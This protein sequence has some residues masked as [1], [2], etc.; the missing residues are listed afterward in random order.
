MLQR[1]PG[2][3]GARRT[4]VLHDADIKRRL[5]AGTTIVWNHG[6]KHLCKTL[7]LMRILLTILCLARIYLH[8]PR[9]AVICSGVVLRGHSSKIYSVL[10]HGLHTAGRG[11]TLPNTSPIVNLIWD[12]KDK[13][14]FSTTREQWVICTQTLSTQPAFPGHKVS[15]VVIHLQSE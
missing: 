7:N 11:H 13:W 14:R 12:A 6:L 1:V 8:L 15:G 5:R 4:Y 10:I 2:P 9:I 3:R